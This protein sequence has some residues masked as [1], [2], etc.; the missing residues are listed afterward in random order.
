MEDKLSGVKISG[1]EDREVTGADEFQRGI[2]QQ[3]KFD[4]MHPRISPKV[5]SLSTS[6]GID[7]TGKDGYLTEISLGQVRVKK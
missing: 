3:N 6:L 1:L 7:K 4:L 5:A 2:L